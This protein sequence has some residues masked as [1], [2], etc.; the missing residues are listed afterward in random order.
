MLHDS[1]VVAHP[2]IIKIPE[3]RHRNDKRRDNCYCVRFHQGILQFEFFRTRH[4]IP[5]MRDPVTGSRPIVKRPDFCTLD[6][7]ARNV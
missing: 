5:D 6:R 7:V 3:H 2:L 1:D 4:L